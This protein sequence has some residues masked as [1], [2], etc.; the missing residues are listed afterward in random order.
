MDTLK[1]S[2]LKAA[3]AKEVVVDVIDC[4]GIDF[5]ELEAGLKKVKPEAAQIDGA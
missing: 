3:I 5:K 1:A 2:A 4:S